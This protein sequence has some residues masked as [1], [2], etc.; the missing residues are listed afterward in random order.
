MAIGDLHEGVQILV[1]DEDGVA[2]GLELGQ[3]LPDLPTNQGGQSLGGLVED[4]QPGVGHQGADHGQHLLL[5]AGELVAVVVE[6]VGQAGEDGKDPVQGIGRGGLQPVG[7]R[8][9]HVFV[10]GQVGENL[11]AFRHKPD[12]QPGDGMA[13]QA[14]NFGAI[15]DN[16]AC[17]HRRQPH[18][19]AHRGA[20]AHAVAA[21]QSD[22]LALLNLETHAEEG[23]ARAVEGFDA[24]Y[25]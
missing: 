25:G 8:G 3:P 9:H 23:L 12:A 19:G 7:G 4:E 17:A 20:L 10:N 1:D 22:H 6:T 24:C 21:Q 18:D 14:V 2:V 11:P 16:A 15:E 5:P 13:G